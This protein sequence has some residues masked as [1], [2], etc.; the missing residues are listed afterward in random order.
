MNT[1]RRAGRCGEATLSAG[2][3]WLA[4]RASMR[5]RRT[6]AGVLGFVTLAL[7]MT[8]AAPAAAAPD[9]GCGTGIGGLICTGGKKFLGAAKSIPG[10]GSLVSAADSATKAVDALNPQNFLDSWA[11]GLCHAVIFVLTFIESTAEKLGTP[12][13]DQKWW[14]DQYAVSFGLSLILLAFLLAVVTAKIGGPEGSVSGVELLRQSGWRLLFV[15]PAC[16]L[17]PAVLYSLQQVASELTKTFSTQAAVQ[18]NGAVGGLLKVIQDTAGKGGWSDMGGTVMVIVLMALILCFGVVLLVEVAI[19]NWGLMM[20]GLLVPLALVSAVYPPWARIL[21]RLCGI[22]LGMM[23]LPVVIFFF[24]W[25]VWSGFN[26]NINAQGGSNSTVTML[27]FLL[28]SLI[29]IDIFPIVAVWLLG[30]V[31]PDT[32]QMDAEVRAAAPQPTPGDVYSGSF[33]KLE[34]RSWNGGNEGGEGSGGGQEEDAGGDDPG[35][36]NSGGG[37]SGSDGTGPI[38]S[39]HDAA[40]DSRDSAPGPGDPYEDGTRAG[41]HAGDDYGKQQTGGG[42]D[43]DGSAG[44]LPGPRPGGGG[45]SGGGAG[46]EAAGGEAAAAAL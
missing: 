26:D 35:P 18:A 25:T 16:A 29:M 31:A 13:F 46:G 1:V 24:F 44:P 36:D 32:E 45:G 40:A 8:P 10:V 19:S 20:C 17:G 21:R 14:A 27:L 34:P 6:F 23:F 22:I 42:D 12:A 2:L 4:V 11:Q 33:S 7:V 3:S 43:G 9:D 28:V 41:S 39:T 37:K 5:P 38:E 30:V 15:V